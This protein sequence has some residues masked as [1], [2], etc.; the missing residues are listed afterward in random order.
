MDITNLGTL[1][2][3]P[4]DPHILLVA[5]RDLIVGNP[6][7][8]DQE[9]WVSNVFQDMTRAHPDL[10]TL[11]PFAAKN[12]PDEPQDDENP[13]C[14][15]RA[16]VAGW[17]VILGDDPRVKLNGDRGILLPDGTLTSY[18]DRARTLLGITY[19]QGE[20]L[21]ESLRSRDEVIEALDRLIADPS[22]E[23]WIDPITTLTVTVADS[24]GNVLYATDIEVVK[25]DDDN[26][27][28]VEEALNLAFYRH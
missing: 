24:S 5:V 1:T 15:T 28:M 6:E 11:R 19:P 22:D 8:H 18:A 4:P 9:H 13:V 23:I 14:G 16:C 3:T 27:P 25:N 20:Y 21:F 17:T 2:Y 7:R 26:D 12:L 10:A